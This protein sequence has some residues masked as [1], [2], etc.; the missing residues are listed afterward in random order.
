LTETKP[1]TTGVIIARYEL[2]KVPNQ[3]ARTEG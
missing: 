3:P 2:E 1:T